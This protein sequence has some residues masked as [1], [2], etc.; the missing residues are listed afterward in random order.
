[1]DLLFRPRRSVAGDA[2]VLPEDTDADRGA[3]RHGTSLARG[4]GLTP[5]ASGEF[6]VEARQFIDEVVESLRRLLA[7][8]FQVADLAIL[9]PDALIAFGELRAQRGNISLRSPV[10][11][12]E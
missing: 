9:R 8:L 4:R 3:L 7:S 1:L 10:A 6:V 11:I 5:G 2:V 12:N